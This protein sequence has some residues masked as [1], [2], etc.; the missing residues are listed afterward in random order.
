VDLGVPKKQVGSRFWLSNLEIVNATAN[1]GGYLPVSEFD[2]E[3]LF[4][5]SDQNL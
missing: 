4:A 1:L 3:F 5:I 2:H